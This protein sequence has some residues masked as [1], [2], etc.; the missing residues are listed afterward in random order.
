MN[1]FSKTKDIRFMEYINRK[2]IVKRTTEFIIGCFIISLA[3]NIFVVPNNLVPG[4]V[5]GLAIIINRLFGFSN[6]MIIFILNI[7]LL[8]TSYI[9]LGKEKTRAT[10]LGSLLLPTFISLTEN[11]NIWLQI[12]TSQVL[13]SAIFGGIIYGF[14]AGMVFRAGFTT[15]GTDIINQIICKYGK[16]SMGKSMLMS[17]GLIVLASGIIFGINNMMYSILMLYII[18]L[19][20]DRVVL[21]VSDNKMFMIVTNKE[22]EI[23]DFI[24]KKLG[25]GITVFSGKG[26]YK[27]NY[28]NVLMTVLPTKDYY[29]LKEGI[30][31]IDEEAFYI[32]TDSYEVFGGSSQWKILKNLF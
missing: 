16:T 19:I 9:L 10:I 24:I 20:S 4:N 11:I 1:L 15:G 25:Y 18:S 23:R 12:D 32:I 3:Y 13:L 30:K 21:G 7:F 2:S 8:I 5:G 14:G 27:K 17:D 31:A 28:E 22:D 29:Q 6:S 26:G